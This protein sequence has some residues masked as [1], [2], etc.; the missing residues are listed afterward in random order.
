[1]DLGVSAAGQRKVD[2]TQTEWALRL[3]KPIY[4]VASARTRAA[5]RRLDLVDFVLIAGTFQVDVLAS[6]CREP[7]AEPLQK[8]TGLPLGRFHYAAPAPSRAIG[9]G[10]RC[11]GK[12]HAQHR[13]EYRF[14]AVIR[15]AHTA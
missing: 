1:M 9:S 4:S 12:P 2:L 8:H 3:G 6:L 11:K 14:F 10:V 15:N 13:S 7:A 5:K